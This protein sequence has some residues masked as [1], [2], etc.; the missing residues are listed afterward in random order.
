MRP[1]VDGV[2]RKLTAPAVVAG[3]RLPAGTL[4]FPAIVLVQT[5]ADAFP[6]PEDF[7]PERFL[8][9]SPPSYTFI[10]FGGGARRC[11]GAAFAVMEMKTVLSTVLRKVELRA[12]DFRPERPRTHHVTQI[13][14]HG[15]RV[16]AT[17]R[18]AR[19]PSQGE[20]RERTAAGR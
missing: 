4:V 8:N 3:R 12:T 16:I 9:G 15:G 20:S 13:P 2:W 19:A 10:P 17:R 1:V 14:A 7:R 11:I 6:D 18:S 5:S